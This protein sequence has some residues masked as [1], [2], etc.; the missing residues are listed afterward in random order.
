MQVHRLSRLR[1]IT[2]QLLE[3][4]VDVIIRFLR[5]GHVLVYLDKSLFLRGDFQVVLG[6]VEGS[7]WHM[8][9]LAECAGSLA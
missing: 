2:L 1:L 5:L 4:Q 7:Y 8:Q 9:I 3:E 6:H